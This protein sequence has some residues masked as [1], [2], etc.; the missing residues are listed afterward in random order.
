MEESLEE[1]LRLKAKELRDTL[2]ELKKQDLDVNVQK[3]KASLPFLKRCIICTLK[4]PCKH[5]KT[6]KEMPR[7]KKEEKTEK[8]SEIFDFSK[9]VPNFPPETKKIGFTVNY[10]G[11]ER[12]YHIDPHVRTTSL[13]NEKR[14]NLLVTIEHYREAKLQEEMKKLEKAKEEEEKKLKEKYEIE[15]IKKKYVKKQKEKLMKHREELDLKREQLRNYIEKETEK[16]KIK[17]K[18]MQIYYENQKKIL[19]EFYDKKKNLES[20]NFGIDRD[21][22]LSLTL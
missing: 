11:R 7:K 12:I 20:E 19:E 1:A 10:R 4:L 9:F 22:S 3:L 2:A 21:H 17:E 5:Y 15:E 8:N 14:F 16:K 13:P 18:K 6:I